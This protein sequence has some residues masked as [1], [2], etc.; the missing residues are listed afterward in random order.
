[1]ND[2][3]NQF[4]GVV[5][6]GSNSVRLVLFDAVKRSPASFFNEKILCGL[7]RGL[8][9]TGHLNE[10]GRVRAE[11]SLSRFRLIFD[12]IGVSRFNLVCFAT[13]AVRDA[14]DGADFIKRAEKILGHKIEIW[15]GEEEAVFAAKGVISGFP[16]LEGWVAD[17][18]GGSLEIA[19]VQRGTIEDSVSYPFGPLRME[20]LSRDEVK[21]ALRGAFKSYAKG[22]KPGTLCLV[23]GAWRNMAKIHMG[24]RNYPLKVLHHY[25][26]APDEARDFAD[27]FSRQDLEDLIDIREVSERRIETIPH[28]ALVLR[29][30]IDAV[31]TNQVVVSAHGVREGLIY[32]RLSKKERK[33]DPLREGAKE[34]GRAHTLNFD[35]GRDIH[36]FARGFFEDHPL[37]EDRLLEAIC[38]M[39]NIAWRDHPNYRRGNILHTVLYSPLDGLT[40]KERIL[41]ALSLYYRYG[42][43]RSRSASDVSEIVSSQLIANARIVGAF[44]RFANA[45][46]GQAPDVLGECSLIQTDKQIILRTTKRLKD[47]MG[48][49]VWMRLETLASQIDKPVKFEAKGEE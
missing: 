13:S 26:L 49:V 31:D 3:G 46:V 1:M 35:L 16:T 23:G 28:A 47:L 34:L 24:R 8:E 37:M 9:E 10:E 2:K 25:T 43:E 32:D 38:L 5:D 7:G 42:G 6:I 4:F 41:I 33:K 22:Q 11:R 39:C 12:E 20:H 45:L 30:L 48:E 17:L 36:R 15:S 18:G 14:S 27:F 40:H 29:E 19:R 21:K 44:L